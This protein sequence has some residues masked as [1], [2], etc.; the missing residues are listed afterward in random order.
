MLYTKYAVL[1]HEEKAVNVT[2]E[3]VVK[4]V[5]ID[6]GKGRMLLLHLSENQKL[7]VHECNNLTIPNSSRCAS[8]LRTP[9]CSVSYVKRAYSRFNF[10]FKINHTCS[11]TSESKCIQN[12]SFT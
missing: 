3:T 8:N 5:N 9:I 10:I 11:L 7:P 2:L 4:I 6:P 12:H 1:F